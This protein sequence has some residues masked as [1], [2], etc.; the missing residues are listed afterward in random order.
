MGALLRHILNNHG[1]SAMLGN[2]KQK[3]TTIL[4]SI[5]YLYVIGDMRINFDIPVQHYIYFFQTD[6]RILR[7]IENAVSWLL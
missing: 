3:S 2:T 7:D 4:R 1:T 6:G 5:F